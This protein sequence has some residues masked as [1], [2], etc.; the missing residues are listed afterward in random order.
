MPHRVLIVTGNT[1]HAGSL[2]SI[3]AR[4]QEG[5]FACE[6]ATT[7][8]DALARLGA[9]T[10]ESVDAVLVDLD[11]S[12]SRGLDTFD[13]L[14]ALAPGVPLIVL[15]EAED[16]RQ[17]WEAIQLGAQGS[18]SRAHFDSYLVPQV[19][20]AIVRR[21]TV[22]DAL[23][24]EKA[25]ARA[26]L[27]LIGDA[28]VGTDMTGKVVYLNSAA[29]EL[30]GW[31]A[32][33]ASGQ[34]IENVMRLINGETRE[35]A[36]NPLV[37]VL[38]KDRCKRLTTGINLIRRNGS[39]VAIEDSAA[40]VHDS[41]GRIKG[42]V[43]VFHGLHSAQPLPRKTVRATP[44][45][46]LSEWPG[47]AQLDDRIT[48]AQRRG[49]QLALLYLELG[50]ADADSPPHP[51]AG[52][53]LGEPGRHAVARCLSDCLRG[54][55][56]LSR[57]GDAEFAVL[58]DTRHPLEDA[59]CTASKILTALAALYQGRQ[60][61]LHASIG[62]AT[63]P[64]DAED[65]D[66]L[67]EIA[68]TAMFRSKGEDQDPY[69]FFKR[70][71]DLRAVERRLIEA[72]LRIALT[73]NELALYYQPK[74][75]LGSG[76]ISSAEALLR[77]LH[78]SWGLLPPARFVRIAEACGLLAP[79]G[80]WVLQ[81]ACIQAKRWQ[82]SGYDLSS[83]AVNVSALEL[84]RKG[85]VASVRNALAASDLPAK[86]LQLEIAENVLM[87]DPHVSAELLK[88][89][90]DM[91]VQL[92]VDDFGTGYSNL[93]DLNRLP[94][95]V[96][97]IDRSLV[98]DIAATD[99]VLAGAVLAMGNSL[100]RRVVAE[101]IEE[102]AQLDFLQARHCDEGQGFLFSQAVNAQDFT[103]LLRHGINRCAS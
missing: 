99:G 100:K 67:I 4:A 38:R 28:V 51:L 32:T 29:Q 86:Y 103:R 79:I 88:Q 102:Q 49:T 69:P 57:L 70:E 8:H 20:H 44:R 27:D 42:A 66:G 47:H 12:D 78:P 41:M 94:I 48:L 61:P 46:T 10:K 95:D 62:I 84:R 93:G 43:M 71:L 13:R 97:K 92:A 6:W 50:H 87:R 91:G 76:R 74:I 101:G 22:E 17:A 23:F 35:P 56:T 72:H 63:Y 7:L 59:A 77:W 31:S 45:H 5:C 2:Q 3:L 39:E 11:L 81:Q 25:R 1:S 14:F 33:E 98:N 21:K 85:F 82:S 65:A 83:V 54:S 19:L 80:G 34:P 9:A 30:T 89:L 58:L 53:H 37:Q 90:K 15:S 75:D 73:R 96:L 60:W 26:T 68:G 36:A 18:L 55:D 40:P 64:A 24:V 16:E 52:R